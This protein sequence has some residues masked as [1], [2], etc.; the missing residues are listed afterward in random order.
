MRKQTESI[1]A[2]LS[3][4]CKSYLSAWQLFLFFE[5]NSDHVHLKDAFDLLFNIIL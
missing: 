3:T 1:T 4:S 5:S 2:L